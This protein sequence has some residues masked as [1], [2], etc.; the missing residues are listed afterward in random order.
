[1]AFSI[2]IE[3][4]SRASTVGVRENDSSRGFPSSSDSRIDFTACALATSPAAWPP[5]PSATT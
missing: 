4:C 5:I 3:T 2:S 1:M